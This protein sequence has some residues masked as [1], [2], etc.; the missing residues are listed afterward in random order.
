[1]SH[2]LK[3]TM[4]CIFGEKNFKNEIIWHYH[5]SSGAPKKHFLKNT[6]ILLFYAKGKNSTFNIVRDVWPE[7][8][9]RKLQNDRAGIYRMNAGKKYYIHPDG[10]RSDNVWEITL[11]SRSRERTGWPTQKPLALLERVIKASSN[12]GDMVLDPFCGCATT[13][14]A[15]ERLDRKWIGIDHEKK[16][17][18]LVQERLEK[19]VAPEDDLLKYQNEIIFKTDP[20]KRTDQGEDHRDQKW[21]YVISNP[22]Y[23]GEYKVGIARDPKA[24]LNQYQTGSPDRAYKIEFQRQTPAFRET[25]AHIHTQF[26]NKHEWVTGN[27]GEIINAIKTFK[28]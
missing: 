13:C 19:E 1:M 26:D 25:E 17:Y 18:D 21:V 2:Y 14:V 22:S 24:R 5:T 8:T 20:P 23:P 7:S 4:D 12:E 9:L 10:K 11:S 15:A 28:H 6:D 16:A 3:I 27:L